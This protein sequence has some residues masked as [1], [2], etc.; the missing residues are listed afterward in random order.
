[1]GQGGPATVQ[2]CQAR[3]L[4]PQ[5]KAHGEE[6]LE[7]GA[8][9]PQRNTTCETRISGV[10]GTTAGVLENRPLGH[11]RGSRE[12]GW[13]IHN[14]E[15]W[16]AVEWAD[17]GNDLRPVPARSAEGLRVARQWRCARS[18]LLGPGVQMGVRRP[19]SL[20]RPEGKGRWEWTAGAKSLESRVT[21]WVHRKE[22]QAQSGP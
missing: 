19:T 15:Q 18:L 11:C 12:A 17:L 16:E 2:E 20:G 5:N 8:L 3:P 13:A 6:T 4:L 14:P 10:N 22:T 9:S 7:A 21:V 1:M